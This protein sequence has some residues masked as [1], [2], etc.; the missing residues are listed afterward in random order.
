MKAKT[1]VSIDKRLLKKIDQLP[2]KPAR[3]Q[4][5]EA[6]L[7]LFFKNQGAQTRYRSDLAILNSLGEDFNKQ[8]L[9]TLKYQPRK[10]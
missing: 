2:S 10:S 6:A 1:S 5:I 9:D 3:S 7:V 4:I 8:A